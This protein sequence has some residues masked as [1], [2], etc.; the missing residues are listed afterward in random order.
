MTLLQ[1]G[2]LRRYCLQQAE[3]LLPLAGYAPGVHSSAEVFFKL[4]KDGNI[5]W[6]ISRAC[7]HMSG[8]LTLCDHGR[9]AR[10]PLHGWELDIESLTY[11]NVGVAKKIIPFR[12]EGNRLI[13]SVESDALELPDFLRSDAA[14]EAT[15]RFLAHACLMVEVAGKRIVTDPWLV[16]PCFSSGWWHTKPPKS[17]ALDLVREADLIYISHNH[18]DHLHAE[19][20]SYLRRDVPIIIPEFPT[21]SVGRPLRRLGFEQVI[22]LKFG[23]VYSVPDTPIYLSLLQAGDFRDDS[24]LYLTAGRFSMLAAVDSNRLNNFVL[25]HRVELLATSFAG[26]ASGFPLCF[27]MFTDED[28]LRISKQNCRACVLQLLQYIKTVAP[29][30]YIPYAGYF[31]EAAPRDSSIRKHNLKNDV[32]S[33]IK[34][35]EAIAPEVKVVDPTETDIIRF[36][37][38]GPIMEVCTEVSN[39]APLYSLTEE[40]VISYLDAYKMCAADFDSIKVRDYF[41]ASNFRDDLIV[42][43]IPTGDDFVP[44]TEHAGIRID[45]GGERVLAETHPSQLLLEEFA[46]AEDDGRRLEL[47]K[48]RIDSLWR[49]VTDRLP[50]ENLSIGF[51]CRIDRKPNIYNSAFWHYFTN[52]YTDVD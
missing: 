14:V 45:F 31:T 9:A 21:D 20:L 39:G 17:D 10:C 38:N 8:K 3:R 40:Y 29:K 32:R 13:Y 49:V 52:V 22:P 27:E 42:Y 19:T 28:R 16:G 11:R 48:V 2:T 23:R 7:D 25:P 24:G 50:L 41:S 33:V 51:Q 46:G 5:E 47:I 12:Q 18:P 36:V 37:P 35:V 30:A 26:G 4:A 44:S 6:V 34:D 1:V 43:L 15:V